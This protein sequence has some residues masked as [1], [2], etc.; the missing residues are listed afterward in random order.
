M[1]KMFIY[2]AIVCLALTSFTNKPLQSLE[3]Q[4]S[5]PNTSP[6]N[7]I[8][9]QYN[10]SYPVQWYA[11]NGCT[12]EWVEFNGTGHTR[13]SGVINNNVVT[14]SL[15]Y[16]AADIKGVGLSSGTSYITTDYFNY[17]NKA[18]LINGQVVFQQRGTMKFIATGSPNIKYVV[19]DN[20]HL[21]L[22]ANGEVTKFYS[23]GGDVI[24]CE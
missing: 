7:A 18:S 6:N 4:L 24:T 20:W 1:K 12:G 16:N 5:L 2:T 14:F 10:D 8:T 17:T 23:T 15:H 19:E 21:T 22:N 9:F 11:W 3:R 13:L